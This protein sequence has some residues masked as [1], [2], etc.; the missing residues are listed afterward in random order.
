MAVIVGKS[1]DVCMAD[2]VLDV[3]ARKRV[4]RPPQVNLREQFKHMRDGF[5][6]VVRELSKRLE[7]DAG[8]TFRLRVDKE[9]EDFGLYHWLLINEDQA[10]IEWLGLVEIMVATGFISVKFNGDV[11]L[12]AVTLADFLTYSTDRLIGPKGVMKELLLWRLK[13]KQ[14]NSHT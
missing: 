8:W 5:K 11:D 7:E 13:K 10:V 9:N 2:L 1:W 3:T 6:A 4:G 12:V 14:T